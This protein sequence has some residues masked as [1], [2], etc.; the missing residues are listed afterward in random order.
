MSFR[1]G[2][3]SSIL[4]PF[5]VQVNNQPMAALVQPVYDCLFRLV[6]PDA[7]TNEEEVSW[8]GPLNTLNT[9]ILCYS[10]SGHP[11]AVLDQEAWMPSACD[12]SKK[13]C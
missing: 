11:A 4:K 8:L 9:H 13:G 5:V 12:M 2:V 3:I 6:Q 1:S 10:Q 7:L